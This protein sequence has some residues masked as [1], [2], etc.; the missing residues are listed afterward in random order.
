MNILPCHR[1]FNLNLEGVKLLQKNF[2]DHTQLPKK[3]SKISLS[4]NKRLA[5]CDVDFIFDYEIFPKYIMRHQ[6]EWKLSHR[7]MRVGD[8]IVQRAVVPPVGFGVCLEFAVR[9]TQVIRNATKVGFV[10]ETL[11]G[12]VE[13]GISEFY[14]E[15][16]GDDLHFAIRTF[17]EPGLFI[18]QATKYI[19]TLPYQT[20]C[21]N[22]ALQNVSDNFSLHNKIGG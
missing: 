16:V 6:A 20:W 8:V 9:I 2:D 15:E 22:R 21:T 14:F 1:K 11:N 12:H 7:E 13:R 17:S 3:F 19:F 4:P 10:Y 5:D 18:T